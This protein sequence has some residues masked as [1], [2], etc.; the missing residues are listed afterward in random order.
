MHRSSKTTAGPEEPS[1]S[2]SESAPDRA[3]P[4]AAGDFRAGFWRLADPKITLA[5]MA[6][7]F[8]GA[9]FAAAHGPLCAGWLAVTVLGFFAIE[10]A[11]NASGDIFDYETDIRVPDEDRTDFSGGKRVLVDGLLSVRQTWAIA[12]AF[13]ALGIAAGAAIVFLR[14]P[15]AIVP[16]GVGLVLAWSYNGPP[17]RFA[18]R[19][20]GEIDVA[21]CYGPL[22]AISTYLIQTHEVGLEVTL[23]S[24]SLGVFIAAFLWVNELPDHDADRATG[25][26]NWVVRL[27]RRRASRCLPAIYGAAILMIATAPLAGLPA[28]VLLGTIAAVPAAWVVVRVWRDPESCFRHAP[29]SAGALVAFLASSL[30]MGLGVLVF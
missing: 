18:Y 4:A 5:S 11:K 28:G 30:G 3:G 13:Y 15:L 24:V 1:P 26:R 9:C 17:G 6:S 21:I 29:V 10:V 20:L 27:G 25:K 16:G 7:I 12:I 19:G 2:P 8:L 22:I 14:E 23:A